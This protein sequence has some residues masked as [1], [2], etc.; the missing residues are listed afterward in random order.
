MGKFSQ[1]LRNLFKD[2]VT[3][4]NMGKFTQNMGN[5]NQTLHI[6]CNDCVNTRNGKR[7]TQYMD[8]LTQ[9]NGKFTNYYTFCVMI[10]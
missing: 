1:L 2:C 10:M 5:F 8:K 7:F 6:L 4:Q 3:T 9:R